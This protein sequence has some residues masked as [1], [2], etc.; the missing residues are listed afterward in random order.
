MQF[1]TTILLLSALNL[2][3]PTN[4][5]RGE[6]PAQPFLDRFQRAIRIAGEHMHQADQTFPKDYDIG[7]GCY[8]GFGTMLVRPQCRRAVAQMPSQHPDVDDITEGFD[9]PILTRHFYQSEP[10]I[11]KDNDCLIGVSLTDVSSAKGLYPQF[12][13]AAQLILDTC[14]IRGRGGMVRFGHFEVVLFDA[15]LL[16]GYE[17]QAAGNY[18]RDFSSKEDNIPFSTGLVRIDQNRGVIQT[19]FDVGD[20]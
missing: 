6:V 11:W 13:E 2:I 5:T 20:F 12:R 14:V 8:T 19:A 10:M 16:P 9:G 7:G 3:A 18:I 17:Q 15:K 4:A 1:H